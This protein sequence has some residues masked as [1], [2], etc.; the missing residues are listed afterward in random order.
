MFWIKAKVYL[1][2][3]AT[4]LALQCNRLDTI[5]Y[6]AM[7][8]PDLL[9]KTIRSDVIGSVKNATEIMIEQASIPI[10]CS[11][12]LN[13]SFEIQGIQFFACGIKE[14]ER[15]CFR[16]QNIS[17]SIDISA[18]ELTVLRRRSFVGLKIESVILKNDL[19]S[20]IETEAFYNL[21]NLKE[22]NLSNNLITRLHPDYFVL[23]PKFHM[24]DGS[25]N[26]IEVLQDGFLEFAQQD[27]IYVDFTAN[28]ITE[29]EG[30]ALVRFG[31]ANVILLL[32]NNLIETLPSG[33]FN[34]HTFTIIDLELNNLKNLSWQICLYNCTIVNIYLESGVVENLDKEF[35]IWVRE[36]NVI[37]SSMKQGAPRSRSTARTYY[38]IQMLFLVLIVRLVK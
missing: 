10:L 30:N 6:K 8:M 18:N 11:A 35:L 16:S 21:S 15:N 2:F 20:V 34:N 29:M 36:H 22:I 28:K 14:I 32:R 9:I 27:N 17:R 33:V 1:V 5:E 24:L 3:C 13:I 19:I 12:L 31:S 38:I 37:V 7:L 23:L 4:N 25:F 26:N